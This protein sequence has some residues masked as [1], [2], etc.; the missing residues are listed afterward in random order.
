LRRS[1]ISGLANAGVSPDVRQKL[2]GH[3]DARVHAGYT[4]HE[5]E[6]L[7]AAIGKLPGL[8]NA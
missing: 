5:I 3:A 1:F 4:H 2:A 8:R 7:R 6:T